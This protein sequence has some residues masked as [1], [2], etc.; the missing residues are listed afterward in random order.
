MSS[1]KKAKK[2]KK[3]EIELM[4][5]QDV[6]EALKEIS[7]LSGES[8]DSVIGV[9]LASYIVKLGINKQEVVGDTSE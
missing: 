1:K 3:Q 4:L 8:I 2:R 9:T 5:E 6:L 7:E